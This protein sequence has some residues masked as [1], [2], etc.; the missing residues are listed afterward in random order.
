[1]GVQLNNAEKLRASRGPWQDLADQYEKEFNL[2][3]NCTSSETARRFHAD[4][5]SIVSGNKRYS[6]WFNILACFNQL[7]EVH[8]SKPHVPV[9]KTSPA[10]IRKTIKH[11]ELTEYWRTQFRR[12]FTTILNL[13]TKL[14]DTFEDHKYT[15]VKTF[16]PIELITTAALIYY[17]KDRR[18]LPLLREDILYIRD[19]LRA[20]HR[21]LRMNSAVWRDSW[22]LIDT[23]NQV[24]GAVDGSTIPQ[25]LRIERAPRTR[26]QGRQN[27]EEPTSQ[28][29]QDEETEQ[30]PLSLQNSPEPEPRRKQFSALTSTPQL[31]APGKDMAV[32]SGRV[33]GNTAQFVATNTVARAPP[34]ARTPTANM[35]TGR[36]KRQRLNLGGANPEIG[37]KRIKRSP[38]S[39]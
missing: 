37:V 34:V 27:E 20:K 14:P 38:T 17:H 18:A 24:R 13:A 33:A 25:P 6:G 3:I 1:M 15:R 5:F 7:M 8:V 4:C 35:V 39:D 12:V 2:V 26:G 19:E 9:L 22:T 23:I 29:S 30:T 10:A 11:F 31:N 21:D 36:P 28:A 32:R 16:A